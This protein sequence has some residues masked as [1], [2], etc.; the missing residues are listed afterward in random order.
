MNRN[1]VCMESACGK[2]CNFCM[3]ADCGDFFLSIPLN[4]KDGENS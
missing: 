2:Y 4:N 3:K 1:N